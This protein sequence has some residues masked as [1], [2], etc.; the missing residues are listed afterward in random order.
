MNQVHPHR[1]LSIASLAWLFS[2]LFSGIGFVQAGLVNGEFCYALDDSFIMMAISRN[3]AFHGVWGLT[4]HEFSSCASSPLFTVLLA[5]FN[6]VLGAPIWLPLVI[7]LLA[8]GGLYHWVSHRCR[9]WGLNNWQTWMMLMGLF[10]LMPVPVLLFGSM[11][12][13][14]HTWIAFWALH[15]ILDGKSELP[16]GLA[17]LMG[18]LLAGIRYEGLFEGGLLV[19]WLWKQK[20][21]L[22]GFAFGFGMA[23][24][25][26]S[27]GLYSMAQGWF[28][29]PNSLVLKGISMNM[30]DTG[31]VL[32]FL[33]SWL[34]KAANHPH[35]MV[36]M[37]VL[38]FLWNWK[39]AQ[40]E[41][42]R[43]WIALVLGMSLAHFA[44]AR[45]NHV[46]RYEAYLM[47]AAWLVF[48]KT[49]C[50]SGLVRKTASLWKEFREQPFTGLLYGLLLL[51]PLWRSIDSYAT[52]T[53]AMVNIYQQQVQTGKFIGQHFNKA[54]V[55]AI[56]IGAI[57]WYSDCKL[58]DLWGLADM[59]IARLKM[60]RQY[61]VEP[62]HGLCVKKKMEVAVV[63]GNLMPHP[64]WQKVESWII[65][66]NAVC[67]RDTLFFVA[68]TPESRAQ[69]KNA[70]QSYRK[71]LPGD[72]K[73]IP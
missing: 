10:F 72:V 15:R 51:S 73:V 35:A 11:E 2:V 71:Q 34:S 67:A 18:A 24:P 6:K 29:L 4:A 57:A 52:G 61:E 48:W 13:I 12:H 62:I 66:N 16:F 53:R 8:L 59:D 63:Y 58:I 64:A 19:L 17:L 23:I 27:L 49:I 43:N 28:F 45:Y 5:A 41:N 47:A 3:L 54:V 25:V 30:Q 21:W 33:L 69:L 14:L 60:A 68:F 40:T 44:L 26:F 46:Y 20:R 22:S 7:N 31:N 65:P 37:L 38:Y 39:S 1:T 36:A 42:H 9:D 50:Q 55:G 32:G 70:L 56:D